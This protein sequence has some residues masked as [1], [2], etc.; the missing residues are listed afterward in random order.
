MLGGQLGFETHR[1]IELKALFMARRIPH[2]SAVRHCLCVVLPQ[3]LLLLLQLLLHS[4]TNFL[5]SSVVP[6]QGRGVAQSV[7]TAGDA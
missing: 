3:L 5:K 2:N 6:G 1:V 4:G 7:Y